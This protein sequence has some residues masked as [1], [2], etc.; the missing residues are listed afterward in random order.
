MV[1]VRF[2]LLEGK[3]IYKQGEEARMIHVVMNLSWRHQY[4][5]MFSLIWTQMVTHL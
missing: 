5:F 3:V 1:G 2:P 4:K